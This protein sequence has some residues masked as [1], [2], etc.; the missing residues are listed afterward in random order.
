MGVKNSVRKAFR[1]SLGMISLVF[2]VFKFKIKLT[3]KP[4][5]PPG[6]LCPEGTDG[7]WWPW[8][9]SLGIILA[10]ATPW[11]QLSPALLAHQGCLSG[12][13]LHGLNSDMSLMCLEL[14]PGSSPGH[15]LV[16][17]THSWAGH[18]LQPAQLTSLDVLQWNTAQWCS[19]HGDLG[20]WGLVTPLVA[21]RQIKD[22]SIC[23]TTGKITSPWIQTPQPSVSAAT[24]GLFH[25]KSWWGRKGDKIHK[26]CAVLP[27]S[28]KQFKGNIL[29]EKP[30]FLILVNNFLLEN[31]YV[32]SWFLEHKYE[33]KERSTCS[34]RGSTLGWSLSE[35]H[36]HILIF[37]YWN[38]TKYR[39]VSLMYTYCRGG[40]IFLF[41]LVFYILVFI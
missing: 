12:C 38:C 7:Q 31:W 15:C 14:R 36:S 34:G 4:F 3:T 35:H 9:S 18:H 26:P 27:A 10:W 30:L 29:C 24:L 13:A 33:T 19:C 1:K 21:H 17:W 2:S 41:I 5:N 22:N 6:I 8:P 40:W 25:Y 32:S 23:F 16:L 37:Q 11:V 28:E 39:M 20:F